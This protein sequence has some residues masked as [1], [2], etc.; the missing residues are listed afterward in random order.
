MREDLK[1]R[2]LTFT[3]MAKLVGENWQNLT[4]TEKEPFET[5]AQEAKEK[6]NRD[7]AEY[8][9]TDNYRKYNEY[10]HDFRKRQAAQAQG[11][12]VDHPGTFCHWAPV[13]PFANESNQRKM[14]LSG[15]KRTPTAVAG[16]V[17]VVV[18]VARQ[19]VQLAVPIVS[20]VASLPLPDNNEWDH[21]CLFPMSNIQ[22]A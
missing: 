13:F 22:Q 17:S 8:K 7:L 16:A 19:A 12:A 14:Q 4:R 3:E 5:Q 2:N 1:G 11:M 18:L 6:Y 15:L 10:L 21:R 20:T 9:K